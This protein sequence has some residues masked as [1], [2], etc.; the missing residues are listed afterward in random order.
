MKYRG[1]GK[2]LGTAVSVG[3]GASVVAVG[4]RLSAVAVASAGESGCPSGLQAASHS[5]ITGKSH[6]G[7]LILST[8]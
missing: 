3:G 6:T 1:A 5:A 7:V 8:P 2:T 4:L